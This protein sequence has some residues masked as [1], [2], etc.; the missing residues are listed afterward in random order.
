M[1]NNVLEGLVLDFNSYLLPVSFTHCVVKYFCAHIT[2]IEP[3]S[4]H[5]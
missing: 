3:F 2:D 5:G 1:Y 4:K